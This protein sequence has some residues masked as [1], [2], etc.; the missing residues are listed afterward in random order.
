MRS[1]LMRRE[2]MVVGALGGARGERHQSAPSQVALTEDAFTVP[3]ENSRPAF[4]H[5]LLGGVGK[6][7]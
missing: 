6:V 2:V 3:A 4:T 5:L 7:G 1:S